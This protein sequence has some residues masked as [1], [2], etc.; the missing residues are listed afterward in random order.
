ML[1]EFGLDLVQPLLVRVEQQPPEPVRTARDAPPG[2]G[3]ALEQVGRPAVGD[4][5]VDPSPPVRVRLVALEIPGR[6]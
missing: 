2:R 6:D 5:P 4:A 1:R 3:L